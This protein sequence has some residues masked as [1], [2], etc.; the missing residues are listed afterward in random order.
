MTAVGDQTYLGGKSQL[1]GALCRYLA[2]SYEW[3]SLVEE[4]ART[5]RQ[6]KRNLYSYLRHQTLFVFNKG[7]RQG[8]KRFVTV[9]FDGITI[10]R[11]EFFLIAFYEV[12]ALSMK[13]KISSAPD[14]EVERSEKKKRK[15][16]KA[17]IG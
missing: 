17:F 14:D 13:H 11:N 9:V 1:D 4:T 16:F 12:R 7:R 8:E 10:K 2:M 15:S 3:Q 5:T 6:R